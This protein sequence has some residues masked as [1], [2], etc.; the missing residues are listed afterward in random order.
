M[1]KNP[2]RNKKFGEYRN[3]PGILTGL[4]YLFVFPKTTQL[5]KGI[6]QEE[7]AE[8][9]G[10]SRQTTGSLENGRYNPS[11]ILAFKIARYFNI[12]IEEVF[13]YEEENDDK[14]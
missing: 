1:Y 6:K 10:V 13:I 11:I 5:N 8:A 3:S 12:A 14:N 9:L 4:K 2:L 7:L